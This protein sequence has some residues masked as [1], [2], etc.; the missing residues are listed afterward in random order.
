MCN[1]FQVPQVLE[2]RF[3]SRK[4][5]ESD[6]GVVI[7]RVSKKGSDRYFEVPQQETIL[8]FIPQ[9]ASKCATPRCGTTSLPF[10]FLCLPHS[11]VSQSSPSTDRLSSI[12]EY[13]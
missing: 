1:G 5:F 4:G 13:V 10:G 12:P 7:Q 9:R 2:K 6:S 8:A 11:T 3:P